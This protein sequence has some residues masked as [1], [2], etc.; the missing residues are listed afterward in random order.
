MRR[1][2]FYES[3][4]IVSPEGEPHRRQNRGVGRN[5]PFMTMAISWLLTQVS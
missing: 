5:H 4:K 1:R 3:G 2:I